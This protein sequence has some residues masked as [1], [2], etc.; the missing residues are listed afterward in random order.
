MKISGDHKPKGRRTM[1]D[2]LHLRTHWRDKFQDTDEETG[3]QP[4]K[5]RR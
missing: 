5:G 1:V 3:C 4:K 2:V